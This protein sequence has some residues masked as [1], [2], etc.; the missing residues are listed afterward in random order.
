[1]TI[2]YIHQHFPKVSPACVNLLQTNPKLY[3]E[4]FTLGQRK[5]RE[6]RSNRRR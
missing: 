4:I 2:E 1:M 5:E 6:V 3:T